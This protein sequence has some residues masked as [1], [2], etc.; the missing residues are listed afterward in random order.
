MTDLQRVEFEMLNVRVPEQYDA[1]LTQKY[2][3]WRADLP[4]EQQVGHHYYD[5]FD[6]K[7]PY[8]AYVTIKE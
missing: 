8:T 7:K 4:K 3:N 6:L 2:G 1:Y 5:V